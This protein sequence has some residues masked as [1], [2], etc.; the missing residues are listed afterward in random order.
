MLAEAVQAFCA[1][2][3]EAQRRAGTLEAEVAAF[4][5]RAGGGGG[6]AGGGGG[7][8]PIAD[9]GERSAAGEAGP[10]ML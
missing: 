5:G 3:Q 4:F 6:G 7:G 8:T 10:A 1:D 2:S 9:I